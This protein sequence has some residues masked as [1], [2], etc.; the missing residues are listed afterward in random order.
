M[1]EYNDSSARLRSC[2]P[3]FPTLTHPRAWR[4]SSSPPHPHDNDRLPPGNPSTI[5]AP[6]PRPPPSYVGRVLPAAATGPLGDC[7]HP[8]RRLARQRDHDDLAPRNG[9]PGDVAC[10]VVDGTR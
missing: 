10:A 7:L 8:G 3:A 2:G 9:R 5:V 6:K 1:G 4:T